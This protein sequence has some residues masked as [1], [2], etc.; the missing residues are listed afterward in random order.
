[1]LRGREL[2]APECHP[3]GGRRCG[4]P[5]RALVAR[6][7]VVLLAVNP[8][9]LHISGVLQAGTFARRD[10]AVRFHAAF[11]AIQVALTLISRRVSGRV[12]SPERTPW[13]IRARWL[14]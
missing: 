4:E 7:S 1:M 2:A 12:S 11:D 3:A 6:L 9:A 10:F 13:A 5:S 8:L 14:C